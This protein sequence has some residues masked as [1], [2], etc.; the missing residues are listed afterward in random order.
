MALVK[1]LHR[2]G[3]E[4]G[5]DAL[6]GGEAKAAG[7]RLDVRGELPLGV[8]DASEDRIGVSEQDLAGL[9]EPRALAIAFDQDGAGFA[10]QRRDLLADRGLRVGERIRGGRERS[11]FKEVFEKY[12]R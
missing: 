10:L 9:R 5:A 4:R 8:R 11:E 2:R 7:A 6:E 1:A 12:L 3:H